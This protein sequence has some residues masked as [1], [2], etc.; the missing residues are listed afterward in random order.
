MIYVPP[1]RPGSIVEV[2]DRYENFVGGKWLPPR[3]GRYSVNLSPATGHRP[4]DLRDSE[5]RSGGCPGR[6]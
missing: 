3:A 6:P 1:G 4:A 5:V 2:A